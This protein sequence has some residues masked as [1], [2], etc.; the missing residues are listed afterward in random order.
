[1]LQAREQMIATTE[2][3]I[4]LSKLRE[5]QAELQ[6]GSATAERIRQEEERLSAKH[7]LDLEQ[8]NL[9]YGSA[10]CSNKRKRSTTASHKLPKRAK[11]IDKDVAQLDGHL[12]GPMR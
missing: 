3:K 9:K 8:I 4:K 1:M 2:Y 7:M 6:E 10:L 11:G 12:L 5:Q